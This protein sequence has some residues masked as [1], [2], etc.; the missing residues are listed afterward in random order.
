MLAI[1]TILYPTDLS[2]RSDFAFRVACSLARDYGAR[3]VIVHVAESP[4]IFAGEGL[5][6]LPSGAD[7]EGLRERLSQLRPQDPKVEVEH[8]LSEGDPAT[9]ILEVAEETKCDVIVLNTHGRT[10]LARLLMG[11]VAEEV[12]RRAPCPVLTVRIPLPETRP[13]EEFSRE[14]AGQTGGCTKG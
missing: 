10:G 1:R 9:E 4:M 12:V 6:V 14:T 8:R 11:S 5:V 7:R 13:L 3:L 2:E